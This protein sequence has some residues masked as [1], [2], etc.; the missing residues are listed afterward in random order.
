VTTRSGNGWIVRASGSQVEA[1][2]AFRLPYP[3]KGDAL[4]YLQALRDA[5]RVFPASISGRLSAEYGGPSGVNNFDVENVLHYNVNPAFFAASAPL[6]VQ[7]E[8]RTVEAPLS[9]SERYFEH[10]TQY[11]VG[12]SPLVFRNW[13]AHPSEIL[14]WRGIRWPGRATIPTASEVWTWLQRDLDERGVGMTR[15]I[16][17]C[18]FAVSLTLRLPG[19][20][21]RPLHSSVKRLLDGV[22]AALHVTFEPP[23]DVLLQRVSSQ[24]GQS[25]DTV[26]RWLRRRGPCVISSLS[27]VRLN[28]A[29]IK[30]DPED[31]RCE[32][33]SIVVEGAKSEPA[34][35]VDLEISAVHPAP[36]PG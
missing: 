8:V 19:A 5:I 16:V 3:P 27:P 7:C 34:P 26:R 4:L 29:G 33:S 15:E 36:T 12:T 2:S 11:R 13:I 32:A 22:V 17:S 18:P 1:W 35:V 30:W 21:W 25:T 14:S 10:Y 6:G 20:Q 23:S 31:H 24:T 28:G 9:P